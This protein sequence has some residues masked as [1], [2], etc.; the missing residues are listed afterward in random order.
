M[1]FVHVQLGF[2]FCIELFRIVW[3]LVH[4][5]FHLVEPFHVA[6]V[7]LDLFGLDGVA[8]LVNG[9]LGGQLGS[10][11]VILF[12]HQLASNLK[13]NIRS[14]NPC[15][16]VQRRVGF[17]E[18]VAHYESLALFLGHVHEAAVVHQLLHAHY[19]RHLG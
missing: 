5:F 13:H 10:Q 9:Q 1:P 3:N 17:G 19:R 8:Q 4:C 12:F 6:A 2:D 15:L 7:C 14:Q 11:E 16:N 18:Q